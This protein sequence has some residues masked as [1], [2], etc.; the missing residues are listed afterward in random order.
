MI[1]CL[2]LLYAL[3][4]TREEMDWQWTKSLDHSDAYQQ[5]MADWPRSWHDAEAQVLYEERVWA[6]TKRAM[7]AEATKMTVYAVKTVIYRLRNHLGF[8]GSR[9]ALMLA[10]RGRLD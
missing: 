9:I 4:F 7:I 8:D 1:L 3:P 2:A 5:F 6:E 10:I